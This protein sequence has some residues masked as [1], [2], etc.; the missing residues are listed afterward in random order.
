M[1]RI[2]HISTHQLMVMSATHPSVRLQI[3]SC[4]LKQVLWRET[5]WRTGRGGRQ[6]LLPPGREDSIRVIVR[7]VRNRS[8]CFIGYF[9]AGN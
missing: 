7:D 1:K 2:I 6:V 8:M 3:V 5:S 9:G 4:C